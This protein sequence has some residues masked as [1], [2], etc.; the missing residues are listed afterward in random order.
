MRYK[1]TET[2]R[3]LFDKRLER[4][5]GIKEETKNERKIYERKIHMKNTESREND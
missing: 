2:K 1:E 5:F 4:G 3:K